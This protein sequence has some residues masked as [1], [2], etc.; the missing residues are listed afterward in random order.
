MNILQ[1]IRFAK[2]ISYPVSKIEIENRFIKR[3]GLNI[4]ANEYT[5]YLQKQ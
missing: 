1:T 5:E 2:N 3:S 4:G